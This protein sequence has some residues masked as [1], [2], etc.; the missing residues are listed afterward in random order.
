[1]TKPIP[2]DV[3]KAACGTAEQ[4]RIVGE[5]Y[6]DLSVWCFPQQRRFCVASTN[7]S[8]IELAHQFLRYHICDEFHNA[9]AE[10]LV[11]RIEALNAAKAH[12]GV[13]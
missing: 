1:M 12:G 7:A 10:E 2:H 4:A 9:A 3:W 11:K 13:Q 5:A 6:D 8:V